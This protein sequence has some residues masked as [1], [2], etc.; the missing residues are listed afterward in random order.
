MFVTVTTEGGAIGIGEATYF[1]HPLATA[2]VIEDLK[3]IY[4]GA[5]AFRPEWLFQLAIKHHCIRDACQMAA[6][7]AL[8]QALWD[9]KGK[10]LGVPVWQLLGGRVRDKVRA[11]L[12]VE[13]GSVDALIAGAVAARDEGFTAIKLKPFVG[14]WARQT[15]A[16]MLQD[17]ITTVQE[18][19]AA[20]G[21]DIDIA[22]EMH[23]NLPPDLA[24]VF[25]EG[26]RSMRPY[27][28]EDP[29]M[30]F[31]LA[32]NVQAARSMG[33]TVALAERVTNIWEFRDYSD[34]PDI[35]ILRPDIGLAGGFT[36]MRKIAAIAESRQQRIVPH[37]FTSPVATAAHIQMAAATVNWDVQGY[38]R[39][40][41]DPW[42]QVV[43]AVNRIED[44]YLVIPEVPGIGMELDLEWLEG[45]SYQPFGSQ[46]HH[47]LARAAD[48]GPRQI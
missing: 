31:S 3:A 6:V 41:R 25:A 14:D 48:G 46:F 21:W 23:R 43:K 40:D 18:T 7:S 15:T 10:A 28:L 13:A 37:N 27:F 32:A 44:G 11:I 2:A 4:I 20:V 42:R 36:Q 22:V 33:G 45:A 8:D 24:G 12:L 47:G 39:E 17:V 19:R 38:V 26:V 29:V 1:P 16:R 35:A 30:P 9:I 5:D 34:C